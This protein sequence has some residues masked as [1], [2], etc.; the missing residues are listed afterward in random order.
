MKATIKTPDG[1]VPIQSSPVA[2]SKRRAWAVS[3]MLVLLALVNWADKAVLGL[4]AVPLMEDLGLSPEQYGVLASAIYFLFSASAIA[5]GFLANR[6]ATRWLLVGIVIIWSL[7]QFSIWLAPTFAIVLI[8]RI[9]LGLGEGPSAGLSFHAAA[10][11]FKDDERNLP[12]ALQNVGSFGGIAVAAPLVTLIATK[13]NWHWAFFAVGCAGVIW[14]ILWLFVG[15][16][17]PYS[18]GGTSEEAEAIATNEAETSKDS[19]DIGLS[20]TTLRVPYRKIFFSRTFV[21]T[22][23][24]SFAAYWALAIVS[25]WLPTFLNITSGYGMTVAAN[26]V[27]IVSLTAIVFLVGEALLTTW[28]MKR[29]TSSRI[30]RGF[31]ASGTTLTAGIFILLSAAVPGGILQIVLTA[32]GFGMGL[33][34]FTT[35]SVIISEFV[36]GRQRGAAQGT[37]VGI[38]TS[39]GFIAPLVFG[40]IVGA[41]ATQAAGYFTAFVISGIIVA[42]GGLLGL[43]LI[44]P[45]KDVERMTALLR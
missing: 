44:H 25:A 9:F 38:I 29:G 19:V 22:C 42:A 14:L 30:A 6:I 34:S 7:T 11:W 32:L 18:P 36:P 40:N 35:G 20:Q 15:K 17:G 31:M 43:L 37:Y 21:G 27:A 45:T 23:C 10:K 5:G 12:T 1:V 33:V 24:V 28:L 41:G 8:S 26:I 13:F 16:E 39:A 3:I 4:V 2:Y